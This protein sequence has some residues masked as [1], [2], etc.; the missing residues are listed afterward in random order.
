MSKETTIKIFEKFLKKHRA[1]LKYKRN[2]GKYQDFEEFLLDT[3]IVS[4]ISQSFTWRGS[5]E[6]F[7]YWKNLDAKW[8]KGLIK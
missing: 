1:F 2:L 5:P 6:G 4:F 8:T 7:D 3:E